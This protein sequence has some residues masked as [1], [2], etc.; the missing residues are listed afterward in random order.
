MSASSAVFL[1]MTLTIFCFGQDWQL[2]SQRQT[3]KWHSQWS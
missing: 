1:S 2:E 3:A